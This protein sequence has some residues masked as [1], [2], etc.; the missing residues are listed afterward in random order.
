MNWGQDA[1]QMLQLQDA[2]HG[3]VPTHS[4]ERDIEQATPVTKMGIAR[5]VEGKE[6]RR[7]KLTKPLLYYVVLRRK[8][9]I[10][11]AGG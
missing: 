5:I 4:V 1:S 7:S 10:Q 6:C 8:A 2:T 9:C 3:T 11:S